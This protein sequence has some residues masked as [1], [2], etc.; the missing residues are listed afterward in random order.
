[1][2]GLWNENEVL[3]HLLPD[4]ENDEIEQNRFLKILMKE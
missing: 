2:Y 4:G 1:M 3:F